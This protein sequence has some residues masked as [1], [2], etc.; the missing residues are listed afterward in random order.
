MNKYQKKE[1][2]RIKALYRHKR[3]STLQ[4]KNRPINL[5][6]LRIQFADFSYVHKVSQQASK[7]LNQYRGRRHRNWAYP[8]VRRIGLRRT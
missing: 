8:L 3:S 2:T 7:A 6:K 4:H 1:I 5:L